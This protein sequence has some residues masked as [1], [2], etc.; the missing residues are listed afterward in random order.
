MTEFDEDVRAQVQ[1]L[2]DV[3]R[4]VKKVEGRVIPPEIRAEALRLILEGLEVDESKTTP[5]Q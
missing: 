3:Q 1:M 2:I 5:I 4:A